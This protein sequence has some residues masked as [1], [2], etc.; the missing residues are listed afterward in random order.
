MRIEQ[1]EY[2]QAVA[3]SR[4][5]NLAS[6]QL[7]LTP[8]ALS[9]AIKAL[10]RELN[11]TLLNRNYN[12]I[13]LTEEGA[14]VSQLVAEILERVD[15]L[16]VFQ[17]Q[18]TSV[19]APLT[20][21][22]QIYATPIAVNTFVAPTI[23]PFLKDHPQVSVKVQEIILSAFLEKIH[24]LAFDLAIIHV[25]LN[26]MA[27]LPQN[28]LAEFSFETIY[29]SKLAIYCHKSHPLANK[30]AVSWKMACHYPLLAVDE[31]NLDDFSLT[32]LILKYGKPSNITLLSNI[33]LCMD[34]LLNNPQAI[35]LSLANNLS[36][37]NYPQK[38]ELCSIT[39]R[40]NISM[41]I[42]LITRRDDALAEAAHLYAENL[43]QF[44]QKK[45]K[46][47]N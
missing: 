1:L 44:I 15:K 38:N 27:L 21:S 18:S 43:R 22:I 40:E 24:E 42:L 31:R 46:S 9:M 12:G 30:R 37:I 19:P 14:Y 17:S 39:L 45:H 34:G 23:H 32:E 20:G 36:F 5:M 35:A 28:Y 25:P 29:S 13:T 7:H 26:R 10:E 11:V 8:Q 4:S 47:K 41:A 16:R 33:N 6:E 2:F 3:K